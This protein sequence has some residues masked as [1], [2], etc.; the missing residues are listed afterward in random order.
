VAFIQ[1]ME[2]LKEDGIAGLAKQNVRGYW[3]SEQDEMELN[4]YFT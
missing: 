4:E 2:S 1:D 3:L